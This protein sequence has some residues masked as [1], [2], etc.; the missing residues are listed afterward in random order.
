MTSLRDRIG[1]RGTALLLV[2]GLEV[3]LGAS[4]LLAD[5]E[6]RVLHLPAWTALLWLAG[7]VVAIVFAFVRPGR[8]G[9]RPG[10]VALVIPPGLWSCLH[11]L[12][13]ALFYATDGALGDPYAFLTAAVYAAFTALVVLIAGWPEL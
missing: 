7:G 8:V 5:A 10:Y 9:D 13:T 4:R 3:V 11:V 2:G 6:E 12:S 1:R